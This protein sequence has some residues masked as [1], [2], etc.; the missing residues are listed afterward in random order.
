M[1]SHDESGAPI[2]PPPADLSGFLNPR[3]IAV[4]GNIETS[5]ISR[6]RLKDF[7]FPIVYV[8]PRGEQTQEIPVYRTLA[9]VPI[10][11]DLVILRVGPQKS[12]E[13]IEECGRLGIRNAVIFSNGFSEI[14]GEG[15][16]VER[17]LGAVAAQAGV[18][19][20][21]P[22]TPDNLF[23]RHPPLF[24][25]TTRLIGLL[26]QSGASGRAI[27]QGVSVG[28]GFS[29]W[30]STGNEVDVE[31]AD[32]I[33]YYARDDRTSAIAGY[34]EGFRSAAKLRRALHAANEHD[35]P[36]VL[37]KI[38]ATEGGARMAASHTGHMV[39]ADDILNGLLRQH[40][41]TRVRDLDELLETANLMAKMPR[42]TGNRCAFYSSSG[43]SGAIAAENAG[44]FG[45][46]M[47]LLELATREKLARMLPPLLPIANPVDNGG[48][49]I[50][51]SDQKVRFEVLDTIL[52]D[53]NIDILIIGIPGAPDAIADALYRTV[54]TDIR[55]YAPRA[56]KPVVAIWNS[57]MTGS[58]VYT[59]VVKSGVPLFRSF[60]ACMQAMKAL[61]DY[62]A[63]RKTFRRRP[64]LRRALTPMQQ[65]A[66]AKPGALSLA[67]ANR[68][69]AEA[70]LTQVRERIVTTAVDAEKTAGEFGFPVAMKIASVDFPHKSDVG[71]VKLG[72]ADEA[73]ARATFDALV[74]RAK[75]VNAEARVDGVLVQEQVAGGIEMILGLVNDPLY[76]PTLTIGMGGI[77]TEV[78]KDV[79]VCPLPV[80][81]GDVRAM[82]ASLRMAPLLAGARGMKPASM[83]SLVDA[84]LAVASLGE[85]AGAALAE[86]D[87]NPL[88]VRSDRVVAVDALAIAGGGQ[89]P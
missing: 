26:T 17:R 83:D 16:E 79:A 11:L 50:T 4:V 86:L 45:V 62:S 59:E 37:L 57:F 14:G 76:G 40:G 31:V 54:C 63:A 35:K 20:I 6:Q 55:D 33:D 56:Q 65:Q 38:G 81:A 29:R 24:T 1:N 23:E 75:Q 61:G 71:L 82:I 77:F 60:R 10:P 36:L 89:T 3:G 69:L 25:T 84:A 9:E 49:F 8:N 15:I 43:G 80:D 72:V 46:P 12:M 30:I 52:A 48:Q 67:D 70:G 28:A 7:G 19:V 51:K 22:N 2:A 58:D 13:T 66:L 47:P 34:V 53:P 64:S 88:I 42:G 27:V 87:I 68:L 73:G 74:A 32:V 39:G 85:S 44:L 41:V 78:A 18:R 5:P 21:G